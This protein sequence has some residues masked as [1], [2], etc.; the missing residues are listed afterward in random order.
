MNYLNK[1]TKVGALLKANEYD[2]YAIYLGIEKT[3]LG[4]RFAIFILE[5]K[6]KMHIY[7][8]LHEKA[9]YWIVV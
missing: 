4:H 1:N 7:Y 6:L 3:P 5:L 9:I 8:S 2:S